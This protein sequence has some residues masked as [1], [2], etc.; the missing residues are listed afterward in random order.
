MLSKRRPSAPSA[1]VRSADSPSAEKAEAEA[2]LRL[3]CFALLLSS[4]LCYKVRSCIRL[5]ERLRN[6]APADNLPGVLLSFDD[7][8]F[9]S[10]SIIKLLFLL[11]VNKLVIDWVHL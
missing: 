11:V 6:N 1:E 9:D 2:Q 3:L 5:P 4:T 8:R 7:D 10:K